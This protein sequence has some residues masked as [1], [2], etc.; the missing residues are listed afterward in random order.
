MPRLSEFFGIIISMYY[1]DHAPPHFHARYSDYEAT[2]LIDTLEIYEG[3]LPH[4]ALA[5]VLEWA[6]SYRSELFRNWERARQGKQLKRI[7]PLE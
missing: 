1:N 3:E 7:Q 4:R 5:M 6:V 2:M